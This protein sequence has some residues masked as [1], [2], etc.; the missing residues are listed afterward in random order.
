MNSP[1]VAG[2]MQAFVHG[3]ATFEQLETVLRPFVVFDLG[4]EF[5]TIHYRQPLTAHV[6]LDP[7][8]LLPMLRR[9]LAGHVA[10]PELSQWAAVLVGMTEFGPD[11]TWSDE[12]A[13]ALEPM[14]DVLEQLAT[15]QIFQP[16]TPALVSAFVEQ[17]QQLHREL[18][19]P[20][21]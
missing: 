4:G 12:A 3:E 19:L 7:E 14:W 2:V 20:P 13:D 21:A 8:Q 18:E 6:V 17:L 5:S 9:Y 11:P 16:I 10:A 1:T 15:P